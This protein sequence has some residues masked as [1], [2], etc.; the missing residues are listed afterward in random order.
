MNDS[1]PHDTQTGATR[2]DFAKSVAWLAAAPVVAAWPAAASAQREAI[3]ATARHLTEIARVRH[4]QRLS[5]EQFE[6][7]RGAIIR[8]LFAAEQLK[9]VPLTNGDS[10][11]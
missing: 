9:S 4:G 2:R 5:V 1:Q 11:F 6:E 3:P 7:L 8:G 10:P